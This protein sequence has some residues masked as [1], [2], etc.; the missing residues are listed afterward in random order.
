MRLG[1]LQMNVYV[2][3][4]GSPISLGSSIDTNFWVVQ[5]VKLFSVKSKSY[6]Q[7]NEDAPDFHDNIFAFVNKKV[8]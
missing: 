6:L 1:G 7:M 5:F 8:F 2:A 3:D 4:G